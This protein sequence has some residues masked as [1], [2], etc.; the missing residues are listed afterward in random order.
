MERARKGLV[1]LAVILLEQRQPGSEKILARAICIAVVRGCEKEAWE[2]GRHRNSILHHKLLA[3]CLQ[4]SCIAL[5]HPHCTCC[6]T[7]MQPG[8]RL[9]PPLTH[10]TP[11]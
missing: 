6:S 3:A 5:Q 4:H 9:V 10:P 2:Y 7:A 8:F 11:I 1:A